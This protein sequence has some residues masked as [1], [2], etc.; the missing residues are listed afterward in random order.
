M[1]EIDYAFSFPEWHKDAACAEHE[2]EADAWFPEQGL[3]TKLARS[4]CAGCLVKRECLG[5]ALDQGPQLQ[6]IWAATSARERGRL[7]GAGVTGDLVRKWGV[8]TV[9]GRRIERWDEFERERWAETI[10]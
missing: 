7:L 9:E 10:G 3:S 2:D 8:H 6:G 5:W 1:L 4:V